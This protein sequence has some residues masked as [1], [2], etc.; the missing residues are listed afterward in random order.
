MPASRSIRWAIAQ[1][2][3]AA[4]SSIGSGAPLVGQR[5][6]PAV[7]HRLA[8]LPLDEALPLARAAACRPDRA[9]SGSWRQRSAAVTG[10]LSTTAAKV[11]A[12]NERPTARSSSAPPTSS[13]SSPATTSRRSSSAGSRA[14]GA[15]A[16][17]R[18]TRPSQLMQDRGDAHERRTWP[19]C[20]PRAGLV[21]EIDTAELT[22][23]GRA[24]R[25]RRGATLDAMRAGRRRHL[26]G[27]LLRRAMARP[28][29]LP[30][31]G[32]AAEPWARDWSYDVADT[33]LSRGVKASAIL[34]MCVYA[35]LLER[36]Q[37][38]PPETVYVVTGDGVEHAHRLADYAAYY[39]YAKRRFEERV[40]G[41]SGGR[42]DVSRPGR[43]LPRLRLV[44]DLHP[45]AARR[46]PPL[47][48]GR[49]APGRHGALHERRRADADRSS[50][51]C[52]PSDRSRTC[53]AATR[54]R[55]QRPGAPPAP[56]ARDGGAGLRAHPARAT[57]S[58]AAAWRPCR[59]RRRGTCSSTSRRTRGRSTTASSTC[60]ASRSTIDGDA[61][62]PAVLGPRPRARRSAA[63]EAFIDFVHRAARRA[64]GDARLPLRRLRVRARSSG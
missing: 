29:R 3:A 2:P 36:L 58:P 20:A 17:T 38:V 40:L 52:R 60:S 62:L 61:G 1:S 42:D 25:S 39:R 28:R 9:A 45:A 30:L 56:R 26:P 19:S 18:R 6:E 55:L 11:G 22:D 31:S 59:S 37:G 21:I 63:F 54:E 14:V 10:K 5:V 4:S 44:P 12:C 41:G 7:G 48:R 49:H 32:R 33:K 34:Q 16:P 8:D 43:A 23:A 47:D 46:R 64:P 24:P 50:P 35:D 13:A 57:T 51:S 15:A 27:D 53:S